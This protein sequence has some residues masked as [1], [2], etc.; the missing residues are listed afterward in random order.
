MVLNMPASN[1][2]PAAAEVTV[3]GLLS[4][5]EPNF[6]L[7]GP[8]TTLLKSIETNASELFVSSYTYNFDDSFTRDVLADLVDPGFLL[9][10]KKITSGKSEYVSVE[11]TET[12][13]SN[14]GVTETTLILTVTYDLDERAAMEFGK[15]II[16]PSFSSTIQTPTD[17]YYV[18]TTT[19]NEINYNSLS[20]LGAIIND[21]P[22]VSIDEVQS[23]LTD[24]DVQARTITDAGGPSVSARTTRSFETSDSSGAE[25]TSTATITSG[26]TGY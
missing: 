20:S 1:T 12:G 26:R 14:V 8:I 11:A 2:G 19:A 7:A 23:E 25:T 15:P 3:E 6:V 13:A 17:P 22:A 5:I 16:D 4:R 21:E 24:F 18:S 10:G 9:I